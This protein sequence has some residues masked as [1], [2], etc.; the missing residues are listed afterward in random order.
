MIARRMLLTVAGLLAGTLAGCHTPPPPA[1][2]PPPLPVPPA[3]VSRPPAVVSGRWSFAITDSACV[4]HASNSDVSLTLRIGHDERVEL[5][6]AGR[7]V[8]AAVTRGGRSARLRF[9]GAAGSWTLPA[10]SSAHRAVVAIVPLNQTAANQVLVLL[11]GGRLRTQV[12]T[13]Y[14]PVLRLTDSDVAG[15][16]WF[17]C[18]RRELGSTAVGS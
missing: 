7:K 2:A 5:S 15:R 9:E 4:A 18:V 3:F 8:R 17:D 6:V 11:G 13:A 1:P 16:D 10:R 14:I 12:G